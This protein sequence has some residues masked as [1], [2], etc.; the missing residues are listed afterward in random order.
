MN[1]TFALSFQLF[2][3]MFQGVIPYFTTY[4]I[5]SFPGIYSAF[6]NKT[7]ITKTLSGKLAVAELAAAFLGVGGLFSASYYIVSKDLISRDSLV[8][9][10]T[11]LNQQIAY[12]TFILPMS[13]LLGIALRDIL[14]PRHKKN[15]S[16]KE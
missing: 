6:R 4:L 12:I 16:R 3:L 7:N 11:V 14:F 10:T 15:S 8:W 1:E 9:C 5:Y 13:F 2:R